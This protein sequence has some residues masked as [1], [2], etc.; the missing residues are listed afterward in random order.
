MQIVWK[1]FLMGL[2][3]LQTNVMCLQ[4]EWSMYKYDEI[5]SCGICL[6]PLIYTFIALLFSFSFNSIKNP[7]QCHCCK[8]H[9]EGMSQSCL[10]HSSF[11]RQ[12]W[13]LQQGVWASLWTWHLLGGR[14]FWTYFCYWPP[15]KKQ[16]KIILDYGKSSFLVIDW[17]F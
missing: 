4:H 7:F 5:F 6:H 17:T 11:W 8:Q 10:P 14:H 15:I 13:G 16:A 12:Q 3:I 1:S 2:Y 9:C